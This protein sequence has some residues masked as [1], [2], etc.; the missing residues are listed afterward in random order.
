MLPIHLCVL[1]SPVVKKNSRPIYRS[2]STGNPFIGKDA[3][4]ANAERMTTIEMLSEKNRHDI[5]TIEEDVEATFLFYTATRRRIDLSN[6]YQLYE[7]CLQRAGIIADDNQIR[8]HD[9]SRQY[10][11]KENPRVE[12]ILNRFVDEECNV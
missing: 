1:G 6:A 12:I 2:R 8:S 9:G 4:L 5:E 11:D 3:R 7:D 10:Y